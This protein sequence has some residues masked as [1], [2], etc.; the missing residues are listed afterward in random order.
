MIW[1]ES[2]L[3]CSLFLPGPSVEIYGNLI[4]Q[5]TEEP[6]KSKP[7]LYMQGLQ[8]NRQQE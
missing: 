8:A 3:P 2:A 7:K 5:Y 4:S 6:L 1:R